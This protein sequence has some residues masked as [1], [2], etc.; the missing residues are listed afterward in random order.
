MSTDDTNE[1]GPK[2]Y[3]E[4][5]NPAKSSSKVL[6]ARWAQIKKEYHKNIHS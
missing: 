4:I 6:E 3:Q 1:N 2:D 5:D